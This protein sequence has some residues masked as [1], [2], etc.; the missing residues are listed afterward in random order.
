MLVNQRIDGGHMAGRWEFPG[1]KREV[2]EGRFAALTRELR[3]ELGIEVSAAD[4]LLAY[5]HDYP[6]Q[7]VHLHVLRVTAYSGEPAGLEGQPLRWVAVDQLMEAGLLPADRP[8]AETLRA[9]LP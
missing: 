8:I 7:V 2:R 6:E 4:E 3:E 9:N 5:T 1:G